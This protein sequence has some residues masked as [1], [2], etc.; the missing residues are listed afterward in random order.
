MTSLESKEIMNL[1]SAARKQFVEELIAFETAATEARDRFY[2]FLVKH[3]PVGYADYHIHPFD[4]SPAPLWRGY[5]KF[6]P[7]FPDV[8][9]DELVAEPSNTLNFKGPLSKTEI[10]F[11][12]E[13]EETFA[14]FGDNDKPY[15]AHP[16]ADEEIRNLPASWSPNIHETQNE[17]NERSLYINIPD[18]YL[19]D[20]DGWEAEV[21]AAMEAD[22][23]LSQRA[24]EEVFGEKAEDLSFTVEGEGPLSKLTHVR[25][26]I[27]TESMTPEHWKFFKITDP[28][29]VP[30]F[31]VS[32]VTG[33]IFEK[34][35][36]WRHD[37]NPEQHENLRG[38]VS[39][40]EG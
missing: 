36:P 17:W 14:S 7:Y 31:Y 20:P 24:V 39:L 10:R 26:E 30:I 38:K 15:G 21:L 27:E 16:D 11:A 4:D 29:D 9:F 18:A 13:A 28:D 37:E 35:H 25:V 8:T 6:E 1:T 22:R 2:A 40:V 19:D 33:L 3:N 23:V 34:S 32:R 12:K 5:F